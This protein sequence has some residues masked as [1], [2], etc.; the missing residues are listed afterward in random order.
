MSIL[1]QIPTFEDAT[2][3]A[4]ADKKEVK[5]GDFGKE[6]KDGTVNFYETKEDLIKANEEERENSR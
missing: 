1:D 6:S 4:S 3:D 5:R 2:V